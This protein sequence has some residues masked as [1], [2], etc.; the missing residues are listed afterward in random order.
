MK[1]RTSYFSK[2][3]FRKNI[4][5]FWPIW[6]VYTL[7]LTIMM[8]VRIFVTIANTVNIQS[9]I[10]IKAQKIEQ[11]VYAMEDS[12]MPLW[13]FLMALVCAMALFYY[14]YSSR[15]CHMFHAL[16]VNRTQLYVT[17][18]VSGLL[19]MIIPQIFTFV[20]SAF[21]CAMNDITDLE[22][23]LYWL[24]MSMGMSVFAF[25][26]AV[27]I[28]MITGQ[29]I[30]IPV[31]FAIANFLYM[32][33]RFIFGLLMMQLTYGLQESYSLG[34]SSMLSP[35][36]YLGRKVSFY[37]DWNEMD[38]CII[39]VTGGKAIAIYAVLGIVLAVVGL[40]IYQKRRLETVGDFLTINWLKPVF[41]WGSTIVLSVAA[42]VIITGVVR[43]SFRSSS[44]L[45]ILVGVVIVGV[46]IF[47]IAQ[48]FVEKKF[49]VFSKKRGLE[50]LCI[51]VLLVIGLLGISLDVLGLESRMPKASEVKAVYLNLDYPLK[52]ESEQEIE[53]AMELHQQILDSKAE[54]R[55]VYYDGDTV[56]SQILGIKYYLKDGTTI[57]RHYDIPT[58]EKYLEDQE[59]VIAQMLE[60][61]NC[62]ENYM[63][64]LFGRNYE[65][66]K[67]MSV[68]VELYNQTM[69]TYEPVNMPSDLTEVFFEALQED[70]REGNLR[71]GP[72]LEYENASVYS[73]MKIEFYN[74]DGIQDISD[75]WFGIEEDAGGNWKSSETSISFTEDCVHILEV[76]E[77]SGLVSD[78]Y[79]FTSYQEWLGM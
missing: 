15:S 23:L 27:A 19:F 17:N 35:F 21:I 55:E 76:L 30:M 53:E 75:E 72:N 38:D 37:I 52:M 67:P 14:M 39:R 57:E 43:D 24:L 28:G 47:F 8:P 41:R 50:C 62:Y 78:P 54:F 25:S 59:S 44:L 65:G 42:A 40:V 70:I 71:Y 33:I 4:L 60:K 34:K 69:Q 56:N 31:F 6:V 61:E 20:I 74:A 18:Y 9:E 36:Y 13:I 32:G 48:M 66:T 77:Q 26:M 64:S 12:V 2:T 10:D 73:T 46:I 5:H 63:A 29:L 11:F 49:R 68:S 3:I 7:F 45:P 16:P 1:S 58:S 51:Q 22:Y 79:C